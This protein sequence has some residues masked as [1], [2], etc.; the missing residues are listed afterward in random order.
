MASALEELE[1]RMLREINE[2]CVLLHAP[3]LTASAHLHAC[4]F[5]VSPRLQGLGAVGP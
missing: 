3:P 2:V 4:V 5:A 1:Y